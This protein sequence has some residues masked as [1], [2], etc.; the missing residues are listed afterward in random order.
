MQARKSFLG[1][2]PSLLLGASLL[3]I[4][5][6]SPTALSDAIAEAL[7]SGTAYGD[8]RMRFETVDQDNALDDADALTLRSRLGYT[9][10]AVSGFS[11]TIEFEDSRS[12]A[13]IDDYNDT[14][15]NGTEYSVIADPETTELD[16]GFL[17][18]KTD[19]LSSKLGR[20]VIKLDNT[21]FVGDVGWR[22][23]RQTFD[24]L[25]FDYNPLEDLTVKYA[26]LEQRNRIFAEEKD[27]DSKDHLLNASYK[28]GL[29]TLTGYGYLLEE[30]TDTELAFDTFGIRFK[31]ATDTGDIKLLYTAEFATQEKS[32]QGAEDLDA[33]YIFLEGG[34]VIS[35]FTAKLGYEVLGSDDGQFGFSTPL[36]TLHAFNG[37]SDQFLNTPN[38]GLVDTYI[39]VSGKLAGGKWV[40]AYHDFSADE[41]SDISDDFGDEINISYGKSFGKHYSAGIKY[42]AY[43]ADDPAN[44]GATGFVDT[45]KIWIWAGAKF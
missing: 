31:G 12:V 5:T 25:S 18:Y 11:A 13:G 36:A 33:D 15:G 34:A 42:A 35:G 24:G 29:G 23:D 45:D 38:E 4:S 30:D 27:I 19:K 39:S 9:T 14:I 28:T 3:T 7:S 10:G 6:F 41:D 43:S 21:R 17:H 2:R 40:V 20:Q 1:H 44:N 26:Y 22:Q 32:S 16:Q 8:F 37:W